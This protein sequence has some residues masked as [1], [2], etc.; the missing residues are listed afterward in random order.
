MIPVQTSEETSTSLRA[1]PAEESGTAGQRTTSAARNPSALRKGRGLGPAFRWAS[2]VLV[3]LGIEFVYVVL[4]SAGKFV[5]WPTYNLNYDMQAEGFRSGHLYLSVEPPAELLAKQNPLDPANS[6]LWFADLSLYKGKYYNY[7][8]PLPA[9]ALAAFKA[10]MKIQAPL[11]DQYPVFIL[12]SIYLV[13][14]ALLIER[15]ARRLFPGLPLY[16]VLLSILVFAFANPTPFMIATPGI[17][18]AAIGGAQA[19]LLVGLIFAFDAL[20]GKR[21]FLLLR[22]FAAGLAW[23][24]A[25]ACRVS[26]GPVAALFVLLTA[27]MPLAHSGNRWFAVVRNLVW[28]GFPIALGVFGLLYYNRARFDD[29]FEFG[30]N[31]MLNTVHIR[32]SFE[33]V[34]ANLYSYFFRAPV[35]TCEF[36]FF[37]TPWDVPKAF[38]EDFAVAEGYWVQEPVV[39]ML[40]VVPWI[41]LLPLA[42]FFSVRAALPRL[43]AAPLPSLGAV[44]GS[45]LWCACCFVILGTVAA[46]PSIG[47]FAATMR[48]LGDVTA[49]LVLFAT[50]GAWSLHRH[51]RHHKWTRRAF[52]ALLAVLAGATII[53]GLLIGYQGY[54]GHFQLYNPKLHDRVTHSLSL[55]KK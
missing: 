15:V 42:A 50:W 40:R 16:I 36:P 10:V 47:V 51:L 25:I 22:L 54:N 19:F 55:C 13:A 49:G 37:T 34:R 7:W 27:F 39:G 52:G 35:T 11:G 6:E 3:L 26:V 8:G 23:A 41:W 31:W 38:P 29:W 30:T 14:G 2:I 43:G 53:L 17:Y 48:Y 18:E 5:D 24:M 20:S 4:V 32:A 28:L 1:A 46:L 45:R 44:N 12:Y 9:L 33:Y 21:A